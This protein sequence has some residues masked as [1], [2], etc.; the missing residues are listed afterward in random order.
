VRQRPALRQTCQASAVRDRSEVSAV[1]GPRAYTKRHGKGRP[2][3]RA[4]GLKSAVEQN[5]VVDVT[6]ARQ[7]QAR[8]GSPGRRRRV[9][10]GLRTNVEPHR[11]AAQP[12]PVARRRRL[13]RAPLRRLGRWRGQQLPLHG[14][15]YGPPRPRGADAQ[16]PVVPGGDS[17]HIGMKPVGA[18]HAIELAHAVLCELKWRTAEP[19]GIR[20]PGGRRWLSRSQRFGCPARWAVSSVGPYRR[21]PQDGTPLS[22]CPSARA[23]GARPRR[24][25]MTPAQ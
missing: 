5:L 2:A 22:E 21:A 16:R 7:R 9:H 19:G 4:S 15:R 13:C 14:L 6:I 24:P 1:D 11:H 20:P 23:R 8:P 17:P 25:T 18:D 10:A 12:A 3:A